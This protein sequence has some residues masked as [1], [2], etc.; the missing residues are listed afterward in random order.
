MTGN[1]YHDNLEQW[2]CE[3]RRKVSYKWLSQQLEVHC[4]VAKKMLYSFAEKKGEKVKVIYF[5]SGI[6]K[7]KKENEFRL[8]S[9]QHLKECKEEYEDISSV[10]VYSVQMALPR[11]SVELWTSESE[12]LLKNNAEELL[13]HSFSSIKFN[14]CKKRDPKST[15]K[16]QHAASSGF[17]QLKATKEKDKQTVP[18]ALPPVAANASAQSTT[19]PNKGKKTMANYFE[20][21]KEKEQPIADTKSNI[22]SE[23]VEEKVVSPTKTLARKQSKSTPKKKIVEDE[24]DT[25]VTPVKMT[26]NKKRRVLDSPPDLEPNSSSQSSVDDEMDDGETSEIEQVSQQSQE[27]EKNEGEGKEKK[28]KNK[29]QK[30][31]K[32]SQSNT[33]DRIFASPPKTTTNSSASEDTP[34]PLLNNPYTDANGKQ[35][36]RKLVKRTITRITKDAKGYNVRKEEEIEE[37]VE[38][39]YNPSTIPVKTKSPPKRPEGGPKQQ[40]SI[41]SFFSKK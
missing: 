31:V 8:I 9:A 32:P 10:H 34:P 40:K 13:G 1:L 19:T 14:G 12:N 2:I 26:V 28:P 15:Y 30:V 29:R 16:V 35:K 4:D 24:E 23:P 17:E 21:S 37:E 6:S 25:F 38:E 5:L 11:D 18:S 27:E 41:A 3:E 22:K 36:I 33:L 39:D 7:T 20:K